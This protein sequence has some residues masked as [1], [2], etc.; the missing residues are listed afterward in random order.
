MAAALAEALHGW[1][2]FYVVLATAAATLMGAMFVVASIGSGFL[3]PERASEVRFFL[4]PTVIHLAFV[5]FAALVAIAPALDDSTLALAYG[6]LG[7]G[8]LAYS[9]F[10]GANVRRRKLELGDRL[11]YGLAPVVGY[12]CMA[13]AALMAAL[14]LPSCLELLAAAFAFQLLAAIR[15]AWDLLIFFVVQPRGPG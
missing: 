3:T 10:V 7:L 2:D 9:G 12:A 8:G 5:L 15:N 6:A 1:H 14:R 4:T 13:A 11:W